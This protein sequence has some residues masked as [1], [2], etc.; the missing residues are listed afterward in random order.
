MAS[1]VGA[2]VVW[3]AG[4]A[5][6]PRSKDAD[7]PKPVRA[8]LLQICATAGSAGPGYRSVQ[9]EAGQPLFV[10]TEPLLTEADV[11]EADLLHSKTRSL[12]R[13]RLTQPAAEVL[14]QATAAPG[15]T[16]LAVFID[17]TLVMSPVVPRPVTTGRFTL[18]GDFTLAEAER[19]ARGLRVRTE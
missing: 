9:D 2:G 4:C 1:V 10:A 8:V 11:L 15:G 16:R 3:L 19:I 18:D 12:V 17:D 5:L 14:E 7:S 13:I 6:W